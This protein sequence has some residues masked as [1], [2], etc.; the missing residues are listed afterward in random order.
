MSDQ[1]LQYAPKREPR[2]SKGKSKKYKYIIISN[3][4]EFLSH[5]SFIFQRNVSPFKVLILRFHGRKNELKATSSLKVPY[6]QEF[7]FGDLSWCNWVASTRIYTFNQKIENSNVNPLPKYYC[8]AD[9]S[10]IAI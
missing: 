9:L 2:D 3:S 5:L 8:S 6:H 7:F 10:K 1:Q 4:K